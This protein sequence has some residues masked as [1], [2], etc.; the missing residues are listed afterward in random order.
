[1]NQFNNNHFI[2]SM[3]QRMGSDV[4]P[5]QVIRNTTSSKKL[6]IIQTFEEKTTIRGIRY[7]LLKKNIRDYISNHWDSC[8]SQMY[9]IL[10][11]L[12]TNIIKDYNYSNMVIWGFEKYT[13]SNIN[14]E[15]LLPEG[16]KGIV[17]ATNLPE[18]GLVCMRITRICDLQIGYIHPDPKEYN[19]NSDT[20]STF[21]LCYSLDLNKRID[22]DMVNDRIKNAHHNLCGVVNGMKTRKLS[23]LIGLQG[24]DDLYSSSNGEY[25]LIFNGLS[26]VD[27]ELAYQYI[28]GLLVG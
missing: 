3:R 6:N 19:K 20:S 27:V 17:M 2:D 18:G 11:Y 5:R 16:F 21:I 23:S 14:Y 28:R 26:E 15:H 22:K 8:N 13:Q 7:V 4:A 9:N 25:S 12:T 1:M 10:F 24:K